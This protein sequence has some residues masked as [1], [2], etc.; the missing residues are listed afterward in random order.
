MFSVSDGMKNPAAQK[1][2]KICAFL[3]VYYGYPTATYEGV[4]V[5]EMRYKSGQA[6]AKDDTAEIDGVAGIPDSGVAHAIG[7]SNSRH[8]RYVRPFVKYTPTWAR[9]YMPQNQDMRSMIAH[10]KLIPNYEL[11]KGKK[12]L[13]CDDSVVRGTQMGETAELLYECGAKEVHLRS[14]CPPIMFKCRFL[15]FSITQSE[16]SYIARRAIQAIEGNQP[17]SFD[18]YL[19]PCSKKYKMMVDWICKEIGLTS[20]K[21]NTLENVL[22]AIGL[23]H[24]QVC[25]YCFSGKE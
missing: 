18:E 24:E 22:Y 25:T 21:Y 1:D 14:A 4:N 16:M 2:K 19:D 6:L 15:N 7:Y 10:M 8:I 9:S 5:E 11:I 23:P 12:L 13:F 3:W 17:E 20:L